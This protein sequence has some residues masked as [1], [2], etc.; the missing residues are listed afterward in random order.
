MYQVEFSKTALKD[1]NELP[2]QIQKRVLAEIE[3]LAKN[4]RHPGIKKLVNSLYYRARV[5]NYRILYDIQDNILTVMV[6]KIK[7]RSDIYK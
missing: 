3:N 5:G 7:H 6:L 4:P 1:L 2:Q